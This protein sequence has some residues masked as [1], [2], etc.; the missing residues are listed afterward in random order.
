[1]RSS[2]PLSYIFLTIKTGWWKLSPNFDHTFSL[3]SELTVCLLR[4]T[5]VENYTKVYDSDEN[6]DNW[7]KITI[8]LL[9]QETKY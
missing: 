5:Y 7:K 6:R 2:S 3:A 9:K 4:D 8:Y 1:M